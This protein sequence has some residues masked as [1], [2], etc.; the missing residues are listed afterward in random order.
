MFYEKIADGESYFGFSRRA[1]VRVEPPALSTHVHSSIELYVCERGEYTVYINGN[2]HVLRAGDAAFVDKF[3]PH[4][5]HATDGEGGTVVYF[6]IASSTYFNG[7]KWLAD[8]TLPE[9]F[10]CG[11]RI[12]EVLK[13]LE[14][15]YGMRDRM[16]EDMK[17]GALTMLLSMLKDIAGTQRRVTA[18]SAAM[19][20][21]VM[22]YI[23]DHLEEHITLAQLAERYGYEKSHFSRLFNKFLGMNL[24]EYL[25]RCRLARVGKLL[26]EN[27]DMPVCRA[28]RECGFDSM[29]TYYRAKA[30]FDEKKRNF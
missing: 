3:I 23:N 5:A 12:T 1:P 9:F 19:I 6:I 18:K 30:R 14:L 7:I 24:R 16:D 17:R 11:E 26:R 20:T 10:S 25:N 29:N 13:F 2:K 28:A 21:E 4:S 8:S 22:K 15:S 27:P